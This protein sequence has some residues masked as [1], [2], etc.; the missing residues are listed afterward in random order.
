MA[1]QALPCCPWAFSSAARGC[2]RAL[3]HVGV[4]GHPLLPCR[5]QGCLTVV[6][7]HA[8]ERGLQACGP[9]QLRLA[10][11]KALAQ[12]LGHMGPD[13]PWHVG[14]SWTREFLDPRPELA[15]DS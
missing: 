6:A 14:Y 8:A 12:Q 3:W 7:S 2:G 10:G 13:V 4:G 9:Q 5:V 15:A 1:V 11:S